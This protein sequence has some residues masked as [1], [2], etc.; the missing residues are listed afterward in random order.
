MPDILYQLDDDHS[1]DIWS[2]PLTQS[3]PRA[4]N[5]QTLEEVLG[6]SERQRYHRLH[7]KQKHRYLLS[8]VACRNI[9]S[10]YTGI[11]ANKICYTVNEHGKPA[12]SQIDFFFNMSHSHDLAVIGISHNSHL[13]VDVEI[14]Q[15][16][17]DWLKLAQRFFHVN[18]VEYLKSQKLSFQETAFLQIWTRKESFIKALGTG[19]STPLSSFDSSQP[20]TIKPT[21]D[22]KTATDWFQQDLTL[23]DEY[24]AS[25]VQNTQIRKIR[26][27]SYQKNNE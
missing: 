24:V 2:V 6:S 18:E 3:A 8:H 26:Y 13:G 11:A 27:Y 17:P 5:I 1:I 9:L 10:L 19:L 7:V 14:I 12:L 23:A 21:A 15:P 16:K 4:E 22:H 20:G 25:V